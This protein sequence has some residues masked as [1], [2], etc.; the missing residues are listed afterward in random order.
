ME[1]PTKLELEDGGVLT[2]TWGD[3]ASQTLTAQQLRD[4]CS[5]AD[6]RTAAEERRSTLRLVAPMLV[7]IS[8]AK[9]VGSYGINFTFA[10]DGHRTGIFSFDQLRS[11]GS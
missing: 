3:G 10:P 7:T 8:D 2:I 5:C 1:T 4:A 6:C 11:L 9:L